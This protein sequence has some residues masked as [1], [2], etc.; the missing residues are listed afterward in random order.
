[1]LIDRPNIVEG[2]SI[3]NATVASGPTS[4]A[5][6][7]I[8]E[9]FYNTA[10][11][12]DA[13]PIGLQ[14]YNGV[15]ESVTKSTRFVNHLADSALHLTS[16]QNSLLDGLNSALT[17][18]ELNYVH[19]VT[20]SI[21]TQLTT[22][23][24]A[25]SSEILRATGVEGGLQTQI[26]N[27]SGP[28]GAMTVHVADLAVHLTSAQNTFL[29]GINLP[30]ITAGDVNSIPT[31]TS[32]LSTLTTNFG[33]HTA[34]DTRHLTASQNV[35]FDGLS[36]SLTA[37]E[38]NTLV[39]ATSSI[40]TQL[41][42]LTNNKLARDGTQAMSAAL[43]MGGF[44]ITALGTPVAASDAA[45]KDYVDSLS[46]G[47]SWKEAT[48]AGSTGPLTLSGTQIVDGVSLSVGAR[49]LVKDQGNPAEN[50]IY[51]VSAS[52][53]SRS[54]DADSATEFDGL[55]IF[56]RQGSTHANTAWIQTA[57]I[58]TFPGDPVTF[59]Q[60]AAAGG[61]TAG[62]GIAITGSTISVKN[63][64]GLTFN[65]GA[66]LALNVT[67]AFSLG[68]L[69][70]LSSTGV[71]SGTYK[72]VTVDAKGRVTAGTNP[73]TLGG[74][75]IT[76]AV[77]K[78]GDTMTGQLL[79]VDDL[80]ATGSNF[81]V[82]TVS[83]STALYAFDVSRSSNTVGGIRLDG[84]M[85]NTGITVTGNATVSGTLT[86]AGN[87]V[88]DAGNYNSYSP[89]L[90]GG[91][92]SGT[93]G[94]NI[95]GNSVTV[96]GFTPSQ[97]AGAGSRVVVADASG[98]INNTYF[99][100]T[101]NS[102]SS[103]VT[104]VMVKVG[105][106]YLRSGTAQAV[107]TFLNGTSF[108]ISGSASLNVLK[109]GDTMSGNLTFG[110][111]G[112]GVYGVYDSTKYQN[113]FSMGASYGPAAD[114]SVLG[115]MYGIAWTHSNAGG[116]SKAGLEHQALFTNA[117]ITKTAIGTGIWTSGNITLGSSTTQLIYWAD[118]NYLRR[119]Q[120]AY[121][122]IEVSGA[123]SGYSGTAYVSSAGTVGGMFDTAGNGGDWDSSTS[124]HYFWNRTNSCLGIGGSTTLAGY[125]SYVNGNEYVAGNIVAS[126]A[127]SGTNITAS[128]AVY[129]SNWLR[130]YGTTGWYNETYAGGMYMTDSTYVR[131]YA[132]TSLY[133]NN[134]YATGE[135]TA[136]SD[137]RIKTDITIIPNALDKVDQLRG[138]T[139]IRTDNG[140]LDTGRRSTGVIAQDVLKVLPEAVVLDKDDPEN[141]IMGVNYGN[142]IGLLI[143]AV[144]ELRAEVQTLKAQLENA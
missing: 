52:T 39:G 106:N 3:Q 21:Q 96:G 50:G 29:D 32:S 22:N 80:N 62:N 125:R 109:S 93:W 142:M 141:G 67:A 68:A 58:T 90:T 124:W 66:S 118:G 35:L 20:S 59:S 129:A 65:G 18:V 37:N 17:S 34:D 46:Q 126:G 13:L 75:G 120:Q 104:A 12:V 138:V 112:L 127:V 134:L 40:Q 99:N 91:N 122:S 53:W 49:V 107:G 30:T 86:R 89:T 102:A 144:K 83:K 24:G 56:V 79:N 51:I 133:T 77:L 25:I 119:S 16:V 116:Q 1:M 135:V 95:S 76:D 6:P 57:I 115:N 73:T 100:S 38:V 9:L 74:F 4:P 43:P 44:R 8:G 63:G 140:D 26:T 132:S 131:T 137:E 69:L 82:N 78:T 113:V 60:F 71:S 143:E 14:M 70:D 61:A 105:D 85:T 2:S 81:R 10:I 123:S 111:Y 19:G 103:G 28:S 48:L 88:L 110:N 45:T 87:T 92:A 98:Y 108:S 5:L 11:D 139:Y 97:T 27:I 101:D 36:V 7:N 42:T 128:G 31:V 130:T 114:G 72:S 33:T 41:N 64:N 117:G 136:Y 54:T 94:I 47:L 84:S 55:A 23:A 15:W 121:G